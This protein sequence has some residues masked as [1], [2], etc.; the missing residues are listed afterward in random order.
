[1]LQSKRKS[2]I[3]NLMPYFPMNILQGMELSWLR[4]ECQYFSASSV[5]HQFS[6]IINKK[7]QHRSCHTAKCNMLN[8]WLKTKKFYTGHSYFHFHHHTPQT[9]PFHAH[10]HKHKPHTYNNIRTYATHHQKVAKLSA[11]TWRI[12][13]ISCWD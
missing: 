6:S 3:I 1:M 5:S 9:W 4:R 7:G 10:M 2:N 13:S 8:K 11:V 12:S